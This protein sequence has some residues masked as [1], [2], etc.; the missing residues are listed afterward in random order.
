MLEATIE[1]R[2]SATPVESLVSALDSLDVPCERTTRDGFAETIRA[3]VSDPAVGVDLDD[4]GVSLEGTGVDVDP[5]A[6]GLKAAHTGVTPAEFAV[7]DYGSV[8]V[9]STPDGCEL[10]SL[11][12]DRHDHGRGLRPVRGDVPGARSK[13]DYRNRSERDGGHGRTRP[14]CTRTRRRTRR[15]AG[16]DR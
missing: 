16:G 10:V 3:H 13:W 15:R 11:F 1:I 7:A 8:V 14:G 6:A 2:M 5:T 12:V 4:L 9:P